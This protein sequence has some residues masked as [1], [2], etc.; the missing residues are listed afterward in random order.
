MP[1]IILAQEVYEIVGA[2]M[3]VHNEL[4][5]NFLQAVYQEAMEIELGLR[6]IPSNPQVWLPVFYKGRELKAK[7]K[8]DFLCYDQIVVEIKVMEHLTSR[9]E[10]QILN[11]LAA[12]R[13]KVGVLINFGDPGRL[14]WQRFVL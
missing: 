2:A 14:E 5:A 3:A 9:D 13:L 8:A 11:Y 10:S 6:S 7:Y 4:K 1:E 12:T